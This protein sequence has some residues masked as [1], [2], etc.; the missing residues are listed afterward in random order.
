MKTMFA[1]FKLMLFSFAV[2]PAAALAGNTGFVDRQLQLDGVSYRFQVYLPADYSV[3]KTWPIALFLHGSGERGEDGLVQTQV[4][5]AAA[6]RGDRK[7]FPM[8]VVMPQARAN[9]RWSGVMAKMALQALDQSIAEFH[10]D[11]QR[12]YLTGLS[13]GGQGVWLLAASQPRKFAAIAPICGFL[14]LEDDDDVIGAAQ[15]K[16]FLGQYPQLLAQDPF[17]AFARRIGNPATWIFHGDDDQVVPVEQSRRMAEAMRAGGAEVRYSEYA[18]VNHGS[19]DR[20]YA[21]PGLVPWLLSHRLGQ[22]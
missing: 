20:A 9:T 8:I 7:R 5:I 13:M 14:K 11:P 16:A 21:E 17:A 19:W 10:G 3:K 1:A 22:R 2:A 12:V 4:G 15:D 6:I 18:G